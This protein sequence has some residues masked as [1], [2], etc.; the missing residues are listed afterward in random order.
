MSNVMKVICLAGGLAVSTGAIAHE[1]RYKPFILGHES[2]GSLQAVVSATRM[3]LQAHGFRVVGQYSPV[4]G[5]TVICATDPELLHAAAHA[6]RNGGFGAV[7]RVSVTQVQNTIQV[8]YANPA[9]VAIAYGLGPLPTTVANLKAALGAKLSF[10]VHRGL[11][12]SDLKPGNYHYFI[13][14][15]YFENVDH[16][17][18][19]KTYADAVN[20]VRRNLQAHVAGTSLVYEVNVPGTKQPTTVFGVGLSQGKGADAKVLSVTDYKTYKGNAYAPYE[21]MVEGRRVIALRP[22]YR[23]AVNFPGTP[24]M[25]S[26]GFMS[27]MSAP[28]AIRHTLAHV[29]G[30]HD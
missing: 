21:I 25:G 3:A 19:F 4:P 20:T 30:R 15:P 11:T 5:A 14:M 24:M 17:R 9:Y 6:R 16:I 29:A 23:I 12:R 28:G 10:G 13:G 8:S 2:T 27:I 18:K 1:M 26:H 22:R 7:Q